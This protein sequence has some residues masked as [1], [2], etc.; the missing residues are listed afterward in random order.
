MESTDYKELGTDWQN[1][2][3]IECCTKP[4]T[5]GGGG[6]D[7]CYNSW[8]DELKKITQDYNQ[9]NEQAAQLTGHYNFIT[10]ERDK[11]KAW[12]DDLIKADQLAKA[13]CSQFNIMISQTEKICINS[14][15]TVTAIEILFCMIRDLFEQVDSIVTICNDIDTCIKKLNSDDL[16]A[17]SGIRK[18]LKEYTV[19]LDAVSKTESD[20]IKAIMAVIEMAISLHEGICAEYGLHAVV[21]EWHGL[22]NCDEKCKD[23]GTTKP[24]ADPCNDNDSN[25]AT[26][27]TICTL[28]PMLT[29]PICNNAHYLWVSAKYKK[30]VLDADDLAD[31]LV[32]VNK[33]KESLSAC[34]TSLETAIKEVDAQQI[35]K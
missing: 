32:E 9:V 11:I 33:K 21:E 25:V 27:V 19:K 12:L 8:T 6:C 7:C 34:K 35:C 1:D 26:D 14:E 29:L 22:L 23:N 2:T 5:D 3:A 18:C 13:L 30:D 16:P 10:T 24:P 15:K 20:L 31:D 4:P 28:K 17:D